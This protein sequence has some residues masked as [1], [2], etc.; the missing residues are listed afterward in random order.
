LLPD[1]Q[2]AVLAIRPDGV[3]QPTEKATLLLVGRVSW[4][5]ID[6]ERLEVDFHAE[7]LTLLLLVNTA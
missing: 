7:Q 6:E 4:A 2:A 1:G 3:H 5:E